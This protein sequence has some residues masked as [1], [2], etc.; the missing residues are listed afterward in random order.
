MRFPSLTFFA[1]SMICNNDRSDSLIVSQI[2]NEIRVH[3]NRGRT[4][5]QMSGILEL[6]TPRS[7]RFCLHQSEYESYFH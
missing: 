7:L 5:A 6:I 3:S 2:W 4:K 1:L